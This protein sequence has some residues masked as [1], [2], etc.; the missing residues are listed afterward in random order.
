MI[1]QFTKGSSLYNKFNVTLYF[2]QEIHSI[3]TRSNINLHS[4]MC[5]L[6]VFQK[7]VYFSG[8]KLF[9]HLLLNIKCL[10]N[11]IK[12]FKPALK[13]LL[14]LHSFYSVKKCFNL[15]QPN[16]IYICRT[17]P[18]TSRCCILYIYSTNRHTEYFKHAA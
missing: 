1:S 2:N 7:G 18:L 12:S 17:A 16:D 14:N 15:L 3:N 4:P 10:S 9:S 13:R 5:N 6:T 11:E 8:I